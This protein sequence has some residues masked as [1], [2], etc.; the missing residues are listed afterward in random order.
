MSHMSEKDI[1]RMNAE[2]EEMDKKHCA[3]CR[4]NFNN[5][6]NPIKVNECWSLKDAKLIMRKEVSVNQR[7]PW[8]Q[9]P[10]LLPNCYNRDGYIYVSP[11]KT[12]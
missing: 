1:D 5:G 12:C 2:R 10:K 7:P 6:N 4:D 11:D 8:D 9:D 3:G